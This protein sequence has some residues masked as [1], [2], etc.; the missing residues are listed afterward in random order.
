VPAVLITDERW[1]PWALDTDAYALV[2]V[3]HDAVGD[4]KVDLDQCHDAPGAL[5]WV[6]R[7][8]AES[9]GEATLGLLRSLDDILE[10]RQHVCRFGRPGSLTPQQIHQLVDAYVRRSGVQE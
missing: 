5:E 6:L 3:T 10:L 2:K 7:T 4:V 8:D 9:D 1:V